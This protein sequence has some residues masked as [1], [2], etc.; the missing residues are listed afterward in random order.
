MPN[1]NLPWSNSRPFPLVLQLIRPQGSLPTRVFYHSKILLLRTALLALTLSITFLQKDHMSPP[2]GAPGMLHCHGTDQDDGLHPGCSMPW[3]LMAPPPHL[4][5]E[6]R[7]LQ[8]SDNSQQSTMSLRGFFLHWD[9]LSCARHAAAGSGK[10]SA[11]T[12]NKFWCG[13][14]LLY[15]N[16]TLHFSL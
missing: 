13:A 12:L 3:E 15:G 8:E 14:L 2:G 11:H 16:R 9:F 10:V 6:H 1:Q 5:W 4:C 7:A